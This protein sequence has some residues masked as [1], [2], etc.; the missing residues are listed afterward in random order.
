MEPADGR[1]TGG[2]GGAISQNSFHVA[3]MGFWRGALDEHAYPDN[4]AGGIVDRFR[5]SCFGLREFQPGEA[6]ASTGRAWAR[7]LNEPPPR[8]EPANAAMQGINAARERP[9]R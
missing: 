2:L 3:M 1:R 7:D 8:R 9:P 4:D 6:Y 5:Y